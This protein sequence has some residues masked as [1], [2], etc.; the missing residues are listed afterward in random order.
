[1]N[2]EK[3]VLGVVVLFRDCFVI[4]LN[5]LDDLVLIEVCVDGDGVRC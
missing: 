5:V 3:G 2:W 4:E 1:M